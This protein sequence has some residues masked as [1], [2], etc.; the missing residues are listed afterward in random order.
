MKKNHL[1]ESLFESDP[2]VVEATCSDDTFDLVL[3]RQG[4]EVFEEALEVL[5]E[6]NPAATYNDVLKFM[7]GAL[8]EELEAE[9]N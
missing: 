4:Y 8:I 1:L 2:L 6:T 7:L 3:T 5:R 9:L